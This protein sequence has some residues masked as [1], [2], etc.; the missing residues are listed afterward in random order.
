MTWTTVS[1]YIQSKISKSLSWRIWLAYL[2]A[3]SAIFSI[4]AT[5]IYCFFRADLLKDQDER[6]QT[7][8]QAAVPSLQTI[9]TKGT[10][11]LNKDLPWRNLFDSQ[12]SLEWFDADGKLI[13]REG[14]NFPN[15]P[16]VKSASTNRLNEGSPLVEQHGNIRSVSIAVYTD[17]LDKKTLKLEGYIR[18]NES[19]KEFDQRMGQLQLGLEVGGVIVLTLSSVSGMFLT[20]LVIQPI[21]QSFQNLK[22]FTADASHELRNPLTVIMTT[23]ELMESH[24]EQ[25]SA[26]DVRKF[27]TIGTATQQIRHLVEDLRF[28]SHTDAIVNTSVL[29]YPKVP[30]D[31]ILQDLADTFETD[32]QNKELSFESYLS[33]DIHIK[34]D[35]RQLKRL[36]ANLLE[37]AIK[38]SKTGGIVKLFLEKYKL[39]AVVRVEDTG[40][41]I[42]QEYIPLVFER[43]WRAES[44]RQEAKEGLGLGLAIAQAIVQRHLGKII[45]SSKVGVGSCFQVHLPLA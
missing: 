45:V 12:Q 11:D 34:G 27:K 13:A 21:K 44:A 42:P 4:S 25:F 24:S 28:L 9:K 1:R 10:K 30:L 31:E 8:A 40:I 37:N 20:L 39:F 7:L 22:Q 43:F 15:F 29:E 2:T 17:G 35:T 38:Y 32:A 19:T 23:V 41:G 16:L 6:L 26:D 14:T 5:S 3:M 36:F 18:V 33:K